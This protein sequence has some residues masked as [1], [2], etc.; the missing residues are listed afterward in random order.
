VFSVHES[1]NIFSANHLSCRWAFN[2]TLYFGLSRPKRRKP[3]DEVADSSTASASRQHGLW[4]FQVSIS[5]RW[6]SS[7]LFKIF[8]NPSTE[9]KGAQ[10]HCDYCRADISHGV[11]IKCAECKNFDLCVE[12]FAKGVEVTGMVNHRNDHAYQVMVCSVSTG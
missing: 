9:S 7:H 11:R 3:D 2:V 5:N 1:S 8:I 10:F 6:W 12:C 4:H